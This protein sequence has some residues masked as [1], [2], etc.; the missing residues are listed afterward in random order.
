MSS[1]SKHELDGLD[2]FDMPLCLHLG[3]YPT[4][5]MKCIIGDVTDETRILEEATK[6]LLE[7]RNT[8]FRNPQPHLMIGHSKYPQ[9]AIPIAQH[10]G[11]TPDSEGNVHLLLKSGANPNA[12]D[13]SGKAL[14]H[15]GAGGVCTPL[16]RR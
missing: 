5:T 6:K 15:W 9:V 12:K 14:V 13:I 8:V 7:T 4:F 1:V 10:L 16:T 3:W 11:V 2:G